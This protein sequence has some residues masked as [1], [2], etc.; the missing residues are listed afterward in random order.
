MKKDEI[1]RDV[2]GQ[3]LSDLHSVM[4]EYGASNLRI[5]GSVARGDATPTSDIDVIVDVENP[6]R[7]RLFARAGLGERFSQILGRRVD[8]VFGDDK[9][10]QKLDPRQV[11]TI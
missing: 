6:P 8:V 5:F 7:G 1:T 2:V 3:C 4:A 11:V 9:F 10:A